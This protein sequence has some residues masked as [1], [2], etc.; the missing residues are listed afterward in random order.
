MMSGSGYRMSCTLF[1]EGG[2]KVAAARLSGLV[3]GGLMRSKSPQDDEKTSSRKR[4]VGTPSEGMTATS[5]IEPTSWDP[6]SGT[7]STL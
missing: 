3:K 4:I 5:A 2:A 1:F 7:T 6:W